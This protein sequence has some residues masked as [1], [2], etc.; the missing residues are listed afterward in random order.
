M[1]KE[2]II[3]GEGT[4]YYAPTGTANP[5]ETSVEFGGTWSSWTSLGDTLEPLTL[6][7]NEERKAIKTQQTMGKVREFRTSREPRLT[8]VLAEHTGAILAL[9]H[10]GTNTD[11][12][13]GASQKAFS[14]V[15]VGN[16]PVVSTYKFGF[17]SVRVDSTGTKQPVRYFFHIGSIG[18][19]GDSSWD[20]ENETGLPIAIEVYEDTSQSAGEEF[21]VVHTVTAAAT[22]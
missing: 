7:W 12:A 13:A 15:T 21:M 17:E 1:A 5:D 14:A 11:T 16:E 10:D 22:A 4:L 8:T 2:D 18:P 3:L 6:T 19:D 9:I 20:K